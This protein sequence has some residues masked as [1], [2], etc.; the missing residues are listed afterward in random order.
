MAYIIQGQ[1]VMSDVKDGE[2]EILGESSKGR[3]AGGIYLDII[4]SLVIIWCTIL[5]FVK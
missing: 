2:R 5:R 1:D 3:Q 4:K